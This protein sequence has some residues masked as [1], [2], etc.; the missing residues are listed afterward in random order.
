MSCDLD[1]LN[2]GILRPQGIRRAP[3]LPMRGMIFAAPISLALWVAAF[4]LASKLL[5]G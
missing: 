5:G 4:A 3:R 2:P 1:R